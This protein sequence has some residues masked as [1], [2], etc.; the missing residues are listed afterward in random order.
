MTEATPNQRTIRVS[1]GSN[2]DDLVAVKTATN[3]IGRAAIEREVLVLTQ[4]H[5]PN[6]VELVRTEEDETSTTMVTQFAGRMT[7]DKIGALDASAVARIGAALLTIVREI[8]DMGWVHGRLAEEH[9]I[10]GAGG[11]LT[12]CALGGAHRAD[13]DDPRVHADSQAALEIVGRLADRMGPPG[14]RAAR[15]VHRELQTVIAEGRSGTSREQLDVTRAALSL[16]S[17]SV[18][19]ARAVT[20]PSATTV[21]LD[22]RSEPDGAPRSLR[23]V[24]SVVATIAGLVAAVGALRWIGGPIRN[25]LDAPSV[26]RLGDIPQPIAVV[27]AGIRVGA[28]IAALYGLAIALTTLL[29]IVT[30]RRELARL[31]TRMSPPFLRKVLLGLVGFAL[32]SST[33]A[34]PGSAPNRPIA[35]A[36]SHSSTTTTTPTPLVDLPVTVAPVDD[37]PHMWVIQPGD[38]LWKVA[39]ATIA[40]HIGRQPIAAEVEGYWNDVIELNRESLLDP[41]NPDLVVPGQVIE[42]PPLG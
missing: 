15:R 26:T 13:R 7:L 19:T 24:A 18:P 14:D 11:R 16:L 5:H 12:L 4:L 33:A 21:T 3:G 39:A 36:E 29:A 37:L 8:H 22:R 30:R 40:D 28:V 6:L 10:I 17:G 35:A 2:G 25:P 9:C 20:E 34:R 23:S 27:L 42:L 31:A 32:V 1:I 41:D 38:H